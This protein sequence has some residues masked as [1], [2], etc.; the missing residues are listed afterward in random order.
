MKQ[1]KYG[2]LPPK[3]AE[4]TPRDKL[5]VDL[6]CPNPNLSLT[7]QQVGVKYNNMT[8]NSP[9]QLQTLLNKNGSQGGIHGPCK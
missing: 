2:L 5:C 4:A 9:L 3:L 6:I 1:K 7:Q 8:I